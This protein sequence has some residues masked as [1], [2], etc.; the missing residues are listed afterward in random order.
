MFTNQVFLSTWTHLM[1]IIDAWYQT[2]AD[3]RGKY[4]IEGNVPL[5]GVQDIRVF[6][7]VKSD[8]KAMK[9]L[10]DHRMRLALARCSS[11]QV[12]SQISSHFADCYW[13]QSE[14]QLAP[15][16]ST[17]SVNLFFFATS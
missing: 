15:S 4:P 8:P 13:F 12:T 6:E 11:P 3:S 7:P 17:P 16:P 9:E 10:R 14:E 5:L 1:E 2:D